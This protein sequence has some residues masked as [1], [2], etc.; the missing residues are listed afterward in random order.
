VVKRRDEVPG[1][2][3]T[4]G[5]DQAGVHVSRHPRVGVSEDGRDLRQRRPG[6]EQ[7]AR[8]RVPDVENL[9]VAP[10][11]ATS[12][13]PGQV[14]QTCP[15]TVPDPWSPH[16]VSLRA[17]NRVVL[18][19]GDGRVVARRNERR[20]ERRPARARDLGRVI[21]A[22]GEHGTV[23]KARPVRLRAAV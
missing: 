1:E 6:R 11:P 20:I 22:L 2:L 13:A 19:P 17:G 12:R 3:G 16:L 14:L 15:S 8:A 9:S 18:D 5:L 10:G 23:G 4:L 7:E 21:A